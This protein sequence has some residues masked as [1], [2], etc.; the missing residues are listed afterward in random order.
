MSAVHETDGPIDPV[1]RAWIEERVGGRVVDVRPLSR[2]RPNYFIQV[3]TPAGSQELFLKGPRAPLALE[4]RSRMLSGFGTRREAVA[5][6]TARDSGAVVPRLWGQLPSHGTLLLESMPGSGVLG[7]APA[8]ERTCAMRGYARQLA[9]VHDTPVDRLEPLA[10]LDDSSP[11]EAGPLAAVLADYDAAA[12][13][14][15][16]PDPLIELARRWLDERGPRAT[17]RRLLHGDAGPNQFLFENGTVTAVIDWELAHLGDP[18][19][20]LGYARYREVLY[21]SGAY[22]EFLR[23]YLAASGRTVDRETLDFYTVSAAL[24]MIAG[25]SPD[26]RRPRARNPEALQRL[27]WDALSRVALCEILSASRGL[28]APGPPEHVGGAGAAHAMA[29]LLLERIEHVADPADHTLLLARAVQRAV[30]S[31]MEAADTLDATGTLGRR[32]DE[33]TDRARALADLARSGAD[34]DELLPLLS[35]SAMRGLQAVAPLAATDSWGAAVGRA[36][37]GDR[38]GIHAPLLPPVPALT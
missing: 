33:P 24:L 38:P 30:A 25:I 36:A 34:D 32:V 7:P 37:H 6:A 8:T 11:A 1:V 3:R 13:T 31:E 9:L 10:A 17:A 28:P 19:S 4:R 12:R 21:P 27:W 26:V 35:R 5:V 29:G 14:R 20:D 22:P 18:V 16:A 2:W 15:A 23:E